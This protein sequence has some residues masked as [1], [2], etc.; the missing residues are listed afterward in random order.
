ME[1]KAEAK[2]PKVQ[3]NGM[4][5]TIMMTLTAVFVA[6]VFLFTFPFSSLVPVPSTQG[7]YDPG[8]AMVFIASMTFG[9]I[10]GGISGAVGSALSDGLGGFGT[11]VPFTFMIKGLEGLLVGLIVRR[12]FV[13]RNLVIAW[14][15][16]GLMVVGGYFLAE[17]YF[18][19]WVFGSSPYTGL[20]AATGELP[21]NIIQAVGAGLIG[22]P[23][24]S[25]L[26]SR[27]QNS[28]LIFSAPT[29]SQPVSPKKPEAG[30]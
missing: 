27:L 2:A 28:R 14:L 9:P 17:T 12:G 15:V 6:L 29:K 3:N 26:R 1:N 13:P 10:V 11:F 8:D 18:I 25:V 24:S 16:G 4:R 7:Y 21:I 30:L 5:P 20:A 23:A 19:A 22:I